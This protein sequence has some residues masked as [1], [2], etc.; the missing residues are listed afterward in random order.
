MAKDKSTWTVGR[1]KTSVA[2]LKLTDGTGKITV[3]KKDIK[4]Y[5]K[6][7]EAKVAAAIAPLTILNVRD[8]YDLQLN[9]HGGGFT[10]Q[11]EA[12]RHAI[13]RALSL[14]SAESRS[15]L[16]KEGFLTRDSRMVERK[17]YGLHKAR[18]GTQFSKR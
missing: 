15:I 2:R 4:D 11:V 7:G 3:N 5:I 10:G 1:R 9:V 17:K 14:K 18:R 16:K 6:T 12:I 8:K 13:A